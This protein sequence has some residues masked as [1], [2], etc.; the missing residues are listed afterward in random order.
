M[1]HSDIIIITGT[2]FFSATVGV[3]ALI[4]VINKHTRSPVNTLVRQGD[5]EL[6]DYIEPSRPHDIYQYPDLLG[7][8]FPIY[9]R[10]SNYIPYGRVPSY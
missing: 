1:T 7:Q 4:R 8:Q 6:V 5:I 2:L 3:Y 10:F 9:E